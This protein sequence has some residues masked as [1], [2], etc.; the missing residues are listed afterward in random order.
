MAQETAGTIGIPVLKNEI[1]PYLTDFAKR[2]ERA[3]L[4][5]QK[6]EQRAAELEAKKAAEVDKYIPPAFEISKGG[7]WQPAIKRRMEA[8]QKSALDRISAATT[9]AEKAK[10]AQDYNTIIQELNYGGELE[11][12]KQKENL[13][14]LQ[15]SGYAA[16]E[17][18]LARYYKQQ[19]DTN[20]DF[21]STNHI[22]NFQKWLKSNPEQYISPAAVGTSLL[23]QFEP[24]EIDIKGKRFVYNP[25]FEPET[26]KEPLTGAT[27]YKAEKPNLIKLQEALEANPNLR[28]AA[29]AYINPIAERLKISNPGMSSTEAYTT[30]ADE[31]FRKALPQGRAKEVY[32]YQPPSPRRAGGGRGRKPPMDYSQTVG[33][34]QVV[35]PVVDANNNVITGAEQSLEIGSDS[36]IG[37]PISSTNHSA[38]ASVY[39]M[40]EEPEEDVFDKIFK[41][42]PDGTFT[43]K[44]GFTYSNPKLR[45]VY[46]AKQNVPVKRSDGTVAYYI[47]KGKPIGNTL[48]NSIINNASDPRKEM[49]NGVPGYD[50]TA[51]VDM[52]K[53]EGRE[54]ALQ[55][56]VPASKGGE[57]DSYIK[58][59]QKGAKEGDAEIDFFND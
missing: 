33:T 49:I 9:Q 17:N 58:K 14:S 27:I 13:K 5:K 59:L 51:T 38:G 34:S 43:T 11:T 23:K 37:W 57:I 29:D 54:P 6:A 20:P 44:R 46:F 50:I 55:L 12:T 36:D 31:F 26:S 39:I 22:V 4:Y 8:E 24:R 53:D 2:R 32:D 56:F 40:G 15:E 16:D 45:T 28:E 21:F 30:A 10:A 25:L 52:G 35:V 41:E 47:K 7:Y 1:L 48:A 42:N 3:E 18:A 19:A